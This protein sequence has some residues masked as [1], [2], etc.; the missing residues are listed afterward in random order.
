MYDVI[1]TEGLLVST[2]ADGNDPHPRAAAAAAVT[3]SHTT[4]TA[5]HR[6]T[7]LGRNR[8]QL[9]LSLSSFSCF[10]TVA[11]SSNQIQRNLGGGGVCVGPTE[12]NNRRMQA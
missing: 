2:T 6:I 5:Q 8:I 10:V 11:F 4:R 1:P 7:T 12:D 3:E 9:S